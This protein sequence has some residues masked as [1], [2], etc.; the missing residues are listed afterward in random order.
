MIRDPRVPRRR[1]LV[2]GVVMGYLVSPIDLIP[3]I[4]PV[5]G[6]ADD[7]L[8]VAFAIRHL[9]E[10]AGDEIVLEHWDGDP[11]LLEIIDTLLQWGSDLLPKP[12]RRFLT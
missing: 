6:Q 8:L 9:M 12:V 2:A 11:D 7:V 10:G 5:L 1:K 4:V 3:D